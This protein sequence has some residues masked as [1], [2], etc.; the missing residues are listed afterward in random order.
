MIG[1]ASTGVV[2]AKWLS[3]SWKPIIANQRSGS[4][5]ATTRYGTSIR[6]GEGAQPATQRPPHHDARFSDVGHQV[7][8]PLTP[9]ANDTEID[10]HHQLAEQI[11]SDVDFI[12]AAVMGLG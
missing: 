3:I 2:I 5:Q 10:R 11:R 9:R 4:W 7:H 8:P 6:R 1:S 12:G